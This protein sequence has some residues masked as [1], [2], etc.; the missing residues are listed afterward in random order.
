MISGKLKALL[1]SEKTHIEFKVTSNFEGIFKK[2][3][4]I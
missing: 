2:Q 4:Q 3:S 1:A